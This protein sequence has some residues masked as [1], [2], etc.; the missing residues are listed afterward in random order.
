MITKRANIE[1]IEAAGILEIPATQPERLFSGDAEAVKT[2]FKKLS[3]RFHPDRNPGAP[4]ASEAFGRVAALRQAAEWKIAAGI[5]PWG[6]PLE[7]IAL[8]GRAFRLKF[9]KADEFELGETYVGKTVVAYAIRKEF[10]DLYD[11]ARKTIRSLRFKTDA[12]RAEMQPRL[13]RVEAEVETNDRLFL[14]I[15][16][17]PDLIRLTD[18]LAHLRAGVDP[19]H[20][21]WILS[22]L[23]NMA[24]YLQVAGSSHNAISADSWFVSPSQHDGAL[25]GGWWYATAIG[26]P[27]K[28]LPAASAAAAPPSI[29]AGRR[30]DARLDLELVRALGRTLVGINAPEPMARFLRHA[31]TGDAI[32]DYRD[33]TETLKDS[34]GARRF[35]ELPVS[36]SDIYEQGDQ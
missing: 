28:A 17:S 4:L 21:A 9:L 19:R 14:I 7:I 2:A 13:P 22:G 30:G 20:V 6:G 23:F 35:V 34:F 12:M 18:L 27:L 32:R 29:L 5:W 11:E 36:A 8:D 1:T 16:K 10:R 3:M 15:A 31:T 25:L 26:A 33:W 24:C